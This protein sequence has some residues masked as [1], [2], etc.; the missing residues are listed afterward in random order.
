M[1]IER[2]APTVGR[3][4][5][6]RA[7]PVR[8]AGVSGALREIALDASAARRCENPRMLILLSPAKTLDM[9]TPSRVTAP[10]RPRHLDDSARLA[11]TLRGRSARALGEL[12]GL[13]DPLAALN[14][15]RFRDWA[16]PFDAANARPAIEAFRG[17]V[18]AGFDVDTLDE[19]DLA[20]AQRH[21]RILSGLY[22][23]LRPLDLMQAYRL[24]MGTRLPTRRGANLYDF[25]GARLTDA[26][27]AELEAGRAGH[28]VNLASNEYCKA[29]HPKRL[30]AP[31]ISPAFRDEKD[32]GYRMVSFFAK[33]ARGAM[34][35]HLVR[36]REV[37]PEAVRA[38]TGLGYRYDRGTSTD[39]VPV[40]LRTEKVAAREAARG[41]A[42]GTP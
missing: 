26:L 20:A 4:C 32:G 14:R 1:A 19:E 5:R 2:S 30:A 18:Y 8:S 37:S 29:V 13:S 15:Q 40:F 31:V 38:F 16:P 25:W 6:D 33:R 7:R 36:E 11:R 21:V 41:G 35:R 17:D 9:V 3:P 24:E 42:R 34:A 27:N 39:A 23:V 22:G 12:M 10:T 28:V